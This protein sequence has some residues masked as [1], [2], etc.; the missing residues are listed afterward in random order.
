VPLTDAEEVMRVASSTL[1]SRLRR[2]PD[3]E[4]G[5]RRDW[6][7][8]QWQNFADNPHLEV[9]PPEDGASVKRPRVRPRPGIQ[10]EKLTF[11]V[12]GY[13]K[14][15]L[16]SYAVFNRLQRIGSLP[17][18]YRFLVAL[19]SPLAPV[20]S[21][22]VPEAQADIERAYT[23]ALL[24]DLDTIVEHIPSARLAIQW[25]TPIEFAILE[26]VMPSFLTSQA[27]VE[28]ELVRRLIELG[29]RVPEGVELGYHLCYGDA[30]HRHFKEPLNT[31]KLMQVANRL[32]AGLDRSLHWIHLPV[33][34]GRHDMA[35]FAPLRQ[36]QLRAETELYLGL[37]HATDGLEGAAR[38][39]GAA[40]QVVSI[41][42]GIATE[43]GFG[44][45]P[46][47]S[48][49]DLLRLHVDVASFA[50]DLAGS[51]PQAADS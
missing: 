28:A 10:P 6:I 11:G 48:V 32:A 24:A 8:W 2:V 30:G 18:S 44:R 33:P 39:I 1:G 29:Q 51:A 45:R 20:V 17:E 4:T 41:P 50:L 15:A 26:G 9:V 27:H 31:S 16:R 40:R 34:R 38:R 35:Y 36:L 14:E 23:R 3:G 19:P 12:L 37:V 21:M 49:V 5:I 47:E 7:N 46:T 42:F 43:C 13:A 25:D 22:A